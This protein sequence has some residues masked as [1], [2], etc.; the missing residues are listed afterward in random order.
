[1]LDNLMTLAVAKAKAVGLV[2]GTAMVTTAL[3]GGGAV[4]MTVVSNDK[5]QEASASAADLRAAGEATGEESRSDTATAGIELPETPETP[6]EDG[7]DGC[8]DEVSAVAEAKTDETSGRDHGAAVSAAAQ[9]CNGADERR[10]ERGSSEDGKAN[11]PELPAQAEG[12]GAQNERPGKPAQA[13]RGEAE[14][15]DAEAGETE[16]ETQGGA[17]AD[18]GPPAES[19]SSA[20]R[21]GGRG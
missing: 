1:M 17:P 5:A 14:A 21:G 2:A 13:E 7:T 15:G 16:E 12:K 6:E 18:A 3:V 20:G 8:G 4:A 10:P 11:R 9:A 19:G